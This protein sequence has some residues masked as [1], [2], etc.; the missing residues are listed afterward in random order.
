MPRKWRGRGGR[1][2]S[3]RSATGHIQPELVGPR[4]AEYWHE[5]ET[6][7]YHGTP[8]AARLQAELTQSATALGELP[9]GPGLLLDLGAGGGLSTTA[10][11]AL[12]AATSPT[13]GPPFVL[14]IDASPA[15]LA[16]PAS[17]ASVSGI[18]V[19]ALTGL[20][21]PDRDECTIDVADGVRWRAGRCDSVLA[22]I[23]QPLPFRRAV[24]DGVLSISAVQWLL[25]GRPRPATGAEAAAEESATL[26]GGTRGGGEEEVPAKEERGA[27]GDAAATSPPLQPRLGCLFRSLQGV[28][29]PAAALA[30]QFYPPKGDADF[31]A[32]SLL[33]AARA[34]G[35]SAE[36][37]LDFPHKG[38]ARKW[39]LVAQAARS[40]GCAEGACADPKPLANVDGIGPVVWCALCW[41]VVAARCSLLLAGAGGEGGDPAEAQR[42]WFGR[43]VR[44]RAEHQHLE[45]ALRLARSGRRLCSADAE[46]EIRRRIE[47]ELTPLQCELAVALARTIEGPKR[48][49]LGGEDAD[50]SAALPGTG[51][52]EGGEADKGEN[53]PGTRPPEETSLPTKSELR[54]IVAERMP[55]VLA[56][57][58][59][60][61]HERWTWPPPPLAASADTLAV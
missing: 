26:E 46:S 38:S 44:E 52:D 7:R 36:V 25:D 27:S 40:P 53:N 1:G 10:F 50:A 41:P 60:A 48:P 6:H 51:E 15:M 14:S 37:V 13:G 12:A 43:G 55:E 39:V 28:C 4:P 31:G 21:G 20:R 29:T 11:H 47:S 18:R 59:A 5:G 45:V 3:S 49:R 23:A 34:A 54:S 56:V 33:L 24:A 58:H 61:P 17:E 30:L 8:K 22:D 42:Q 57:L 16:A 32:R 9:C 35:F 19:A 2:S